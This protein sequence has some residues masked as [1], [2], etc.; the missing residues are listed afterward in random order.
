M[1]V[2]PFF[3]SGIIACGSL[4]LT[5]PWKDE[6]S[7]AQK[8]VRIFPTN[9]VVLTYYRKFE[10]L[11]MVSFWG[12]LSRFSVRLFYIWGHFGLQLLV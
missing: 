11:L 12:H 8:Q 10:W 2:L 9:S 5:Q 6:K 3:A 7:L 1:F 4:A